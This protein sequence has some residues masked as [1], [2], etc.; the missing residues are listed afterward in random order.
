[1]LTFFVFFREKK[2]WRFMR[3]VLQADGSYEM[4][5]LFFIIQN[6][7][8]CSCDR[9]F[10]YYQFKHQYNPYILLFE[11]SKYTPNNAM[12]GRCVMKGILT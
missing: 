12:S 9:G 2:P 1:M 8:C 11:E 4:S 7:I 3:I 10:M 5:K 6:V